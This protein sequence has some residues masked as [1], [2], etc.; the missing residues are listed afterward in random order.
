MCGIVG[1]IDNQGADLKTI[2]GSMNDR[3][4]HRGP[5]GLGTYFHKNVGIGHRRL[6]FIDLDGGAQPLSN[7]DES[8]WI[9]YNGELYNFQELRKELEGFGYT[10]KTKS[11]TE[12]IVYSYQKWGRDCVKRFRGMFAF[13]IV[14]KRKEQVFL[15][16]DHIGIKPLFYSCNIGF[17]TF[18]SELQAFKSIPTMDFELD[19]KA[20]DEYLWLQYIPAPYTVFKKI[21]KL[22]P[23]YSVTFGFDGKIQD[24]S[25]YWEL[26]FNPNT[27]KTEAQFLAELELK[28]KDSV[29][30]HLVSDVPFGA[31]LSGGIDSSLVVTYMTQ[32][33]NEKVKTFSIGFEEQEFSELDYAKQVADQLGTEHHV[34]VVKPDALGILPKIVQHYGEPFGDSSAIPT[35]YVCQMSRKE[36]K[37]VLS[38][39]GGDEAFAGYKTY[40]SFMNYEIVDGRPAWK[41]STY[42]LMSKIAPSKYPS[43][44]SLDKWFKYIQYL[45]ADWRTSLWKSDLNDVVV[46]RH[47]EF[48][49]FYN[50]AKKFGFIQ[51]LQY[52]DL[53]TYLPYDILTKVDVASMMHSLEV[54]TPLTDAEIWEFAATIPEYMNMRRINGKYEGKLLLKKILAKHYS[55]EFVYRKKMGFAIPITKW[56]SEGNSTGDMVRDVLLSSDS[57]TSQYFSKFGVSRILNSDNYGAMWLLL[58][59]E[60]WLKDFEDQK[61]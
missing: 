45:S 39:D 58:F 28:I 14:D 2:V 27:T 51:K 22:R 15:A 57:K 8:I 56:F 4:E 59:L 53:R 47:S 17:T 31:F 9:T 6:S 38:G 52:M 11:D 48:D 25:R 33:L 20:I 55:H 26:N 19:L 10:F 32:V 46:K 41:D 49:R 29:E 12:V 35:Y 37:M 30:K 7:S 3:L 43:R 36:V 54:R 34:E 40:A 21:R 1:Y 5:D 42:D 24:E 13:A 60:Y 44:H 50:D 16:R 61:I 18:A 23:G